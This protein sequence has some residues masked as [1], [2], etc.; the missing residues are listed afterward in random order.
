MYTSQPLG[1]RDCQVRKRLSLQRSCRPMTATGSQVNFTYVCSPLCTGTVCTLRTW[2]VQGATGTVCRGG[3]R[4]L[5]WRH[6]LWIY[7]PLSATRRCP[8]RC[9]A[10]HY[11]A[12]ERL[13]LFCPGAPCH[14]PMPR[15]HVP[16]RLRRHGLRRGPGRDNLCTI[17]RLQSVQN[18]H[19]V[20]DGTTSCVKK[21]LC[22]SLFCERAWGPPRS[23]LSRCLG[24]CW[25][26]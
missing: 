6:P 21:A 1:H 26:H 23:R 15:I 25:K 8:S 13:P 19:I 3:C 7:L 24:C 17:N 14:T 20:S 9:A 10:C 11:P 16:L 22:L 4:P 18:Q 2:W 12:L 5:F